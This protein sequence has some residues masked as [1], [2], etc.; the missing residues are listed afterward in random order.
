M[1]I[2]SII[3]RTYNARFAK[4]THFQ[5]LLENERVSLNCHNINT[6]GATFG[7]Y[8]LRRFG[9]GLDTAFPV[10]Q[11]FTDMTLTFYASE[12][13]FERKYF[14]EWRNLRIYNQESHRFNY[15]NEYVRD[16][17][18]VQYNTKWEETQR[19]TVYEAYPTAISPLEYS[20]QST[21]QIMT[22]NVSFSFYNYKTVD[23][24]TF[25]PSQQPDPTPI[26]QQD[27]SYEFELE[28]ISDR[29]DNERIFGT[30]STLNRRFRD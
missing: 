15:Y 26:G 30:G 14:E 29:T 6:P 9:I 20:Y 2:D 3:S 28:P 27:Q 4:P 24:I 7:T 11:T 21:D 19:T 25:I 8:N 13:M 17:V 10:S 23:Q 12:D 5:V 1:D 18:I 22:F 16:I